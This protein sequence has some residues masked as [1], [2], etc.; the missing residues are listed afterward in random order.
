VYLGG[1]SFV[2]DISSLLAKECFHD[3]E[4]HVEGTTISAVKAILAARS[5]SFERQ[6]TGGFQEGAISPSSPVEA[7]AAPSS[8]TPKGRL[9]VEIKDV[10][11]DT[12]FKA[13]QKCGP[14]KPKKWMMVR[15]ITKKKR[16]NGGNRLSALLAHIRMDFSAPTSL[17]LWWPLRTP[18]LSQ[19]PVSVFLLKPPK[20]QEGSRF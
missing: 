11:A 3:V 20:C 8:K 6:F 12:V 5:D 7:E 19:P 17:P 2:Q 15:E 13:L 18:S 1:R 9:Q 10:D 16:R 4:F 14:I